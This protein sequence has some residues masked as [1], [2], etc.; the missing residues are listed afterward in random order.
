LLSVSK[1]CLGAASWALVCLGLVEARARV[2]LAFDRL[3][4]AGLAV[5]G[6][7]AASS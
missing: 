7:R 5:A 2:A 6:L 4:L 3:A 1:P